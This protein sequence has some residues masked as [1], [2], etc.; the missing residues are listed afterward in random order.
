VK[1]ALHVN[2]SI[3][4]SECSD[5]ID[6]SA[7]DSDASTAPIYNYLID[8]GFGLNILIYSGDDDGICPTVGTQDWIWSL[9][10]SVAFGRE[11]QQQSLN[12][13]PVGYLTRFETG[14]TK[15]AFLTVHDAGHEVPTFQPEIALDIFKK[16]LRGDY[17]N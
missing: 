8:G 6:Y 12:N 13:Q 14:V 4:W 5:I 10:Y 1:K 17:T 9:G 3:Q 2:P 16:F 15:L 11:W 7:E